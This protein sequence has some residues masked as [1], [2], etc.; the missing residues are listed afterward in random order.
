MAPRGPT[1]AGGADHLP[2]Q[3]LDCP[4]L[5]QADRILV[6]YSG[7][8]DSTVLLHLLATLR[9]QG[10]LHARISALHVH[11]GLHSQADAWL[12]QCRRQAAAL[13]VDFVSRQVQVDTQGPASLEEAAREA[14]YAIFA[15]L[16]TPG[17]V[18]VLAHH[19]DDQ[20]ETV[21]LHLL[22]GSGPRGLAGMPQRRSLGAGQL[23]RPLLQAT[24]AQLQDYARQQELTWVDDPS[25]A[26]PRHTRNFLRHCIIPQLQSLSAG[27]PAAVLRSAR[28]NGE[29][30]TLLEELAAADLQQAQGERRN[31]LRLAVLAG[32]SQA[33][34]RN[35]LRFWVRGLQDELGGCDITHQALQHCV[36]QLLP[37][38]ADA[39][40][41]IAWGAPP[42]RLELRRYRDSL[43]LVRA[44]PQLPA[45]ISWDPA[46]PLVLPGVLGTL[47]CE[48]AGR[49]PVPGS[50]PQLEVRFRA[51]GERL[52]LPGRP[53]RPLKLLLQESAVPPWLRPCVPLI[54]CNGMLLAAGDLFVQTAWPAQVPEKTAT[55][56]WERLQLHCGY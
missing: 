44:M 49:A 28:L 47:R 23:C 5:L 46:G 51:G 36:T 26:D 56:H 22:R 18:L 33:R 30:E 17:A 52:Q 34:V 9:R 32:W 41:V 16:L 55:F 13:G 43:Y 14:R 2:G 53:T 38:R 29:A 25:N 15:E 54:C 7:G 48:V 42:A 6:G 50:W 10:R 27:L 24:R 12:E 4:E 20:V 11:H 3:V 45:S 21:L 39:M 8:L 35:L 37:A 19:A 40:P 1:E 31:Q